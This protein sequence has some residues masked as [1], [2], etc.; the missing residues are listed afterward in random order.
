MRKVEWISHR[1]ESF[2][3]PENT[4]SAF[5]LAMERETDGIETDIHLTGDGAVVCIHDPD[6][7]RVGNRKLPVET[8]PLNEL[9]EVDVSNGMAEFRGEKIPLFRSADSPSGPGVFCGSQAE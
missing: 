4:I 6:T 9:Q 1:G 3:A 5:Q 8:T 7:G 2:D